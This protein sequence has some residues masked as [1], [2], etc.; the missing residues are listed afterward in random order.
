M[1]L[2]DEYTCILNFFV[3][4]DEKCVDSRW[5]SPRTSKHQFITGLPMA[6]QSE[7]G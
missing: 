6:N 5:E 3:P 7:N 4:L 1:T 2:V